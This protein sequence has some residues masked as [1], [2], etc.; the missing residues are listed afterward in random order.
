MKNNINVNLFNADKAMAD[1]VADFMNK[2]VWGITLSYTYK[3]EIES[4]KAAIVGL[5]KCKGS[6]LGDSAEADIAIL[7]AEIERLSTEL[8]KK[9]EEEATF[10]FTDADKELY[11]SYKNATTEAMIYTAMEKWFSKYYLEVAGTL[12]IHDMMTAVSGVVANTTRGIINS[13]ATV[14]TKK[15]SQADF[16]K[17]FYGR[18]SEKMLE[19]GTLKPTAIPEDVREFYAPKKKDKKEKKAKKG[20]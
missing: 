3:K 11:R 17:A 1:R 18:L 12:F 15:R 8:R 5:E 2:K 14:F 9:K 10:S 16:M 7:T 20:E 19:A 4:H 13:G 6:I